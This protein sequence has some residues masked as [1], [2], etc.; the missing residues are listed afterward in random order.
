M[1]ATL[2]V[3]LAFANHSEQSVPYKLTS[4]EAKEVRAIFQHLRSSDENVKTLKLSQQNLTNLVNYF[5]NRYIESATGITLASDTLNIQISLR[6]PEN[7]LARYLNLHFKLTYVDSAF[8]LHSLQ[9][10]SIALADEFS[11][12][13]LKFLLN[14]SSLKNIYSGMQ[15]ALETLEIKPRCLTVSYRIKS[16]KETTLAM[17]A[18]QQA[19]WFYQQQITKIIEAHDPEWRL[20][21]AELLQPLF[22]LAYLRST[23][24]TAINENKIVIIAVSRYVNHSEIQRYLPF[25]VMVEHQP[26]YATFLYKRIDMAQH[27]MTSALLTAVGNGSLAIMLGQEKELRDA[28]LGSGFSFIDLAGDRAGI[29]FG[30]MAV[31]TPETARHL[32]KVM[33]EINDYRAFMPEVRDLPENISDKMFKDKF[34]SIYSPAYQEILKKI[35]TRI[36]ALPIYQ[37]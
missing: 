2:I 29:R 10:G 3:A 32:Q 6:L 9:I 22:K 15:S 27:F 5:L 37:M 36:A 12:L 20:S 26:Q 23:P 13:L 31:E 19:L 28:K 4:S 30:S 21:L 24:E 18:D 34:G 14:Y 16:I 25:D 35:D 1:I 11:Q 33:S 8:T 17:T 7:S